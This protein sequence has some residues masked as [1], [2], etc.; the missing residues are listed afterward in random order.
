[1]LA[2]SLLLSTIWVVVGSGPLWLPPVLFVAV[3][4]GNQELTAVFARAGG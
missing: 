1:M 4:L 3:A 2:L